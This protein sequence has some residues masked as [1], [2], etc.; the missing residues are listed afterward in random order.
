MIDD[1]KQCDFDSG[2]VVLYYIKTPF[3]N[4]DD[5]YHLWFVFLMFVGLMTHCV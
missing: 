3:K 4:T 1:M 5:V 2:E